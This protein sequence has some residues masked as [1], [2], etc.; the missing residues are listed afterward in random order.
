MTSAMG[1]LSYSRLKLSVEYEVLPSESIMYLGAWVQASDAVFSGCG[2]LG[3][4]ALAGR[5]SLGWALISTA[6]WSGY[7]LLS[8]C[9]CEQEATVVVMPSPQ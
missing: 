9:C 8:D 7:S 2:N 3:C 4:E 5:E 1:A 6:S